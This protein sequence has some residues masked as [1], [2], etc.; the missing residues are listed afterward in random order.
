MKARIYEAHKNLHRQDKG[1]RRVV[2]M[3]IKILNL[4]AGIGGNRKL[5]IG[6]IEVTAVEI[7]P[8]IAKI[9]QDFFPQ[10]KVIIA[11]AHQFLLEHFKE[12]D[13]IWSSP[14]CQTHSD[15]NFFLNAQGV[16]RYPDM[17]LWQEIIFLKH[18]AKCLWVVENVQ[19]Y[20]K[21]FVKPYLCGRH[22]FWSNFIIANRKM[23]PSI[24]TFN[25]SA[26]IIKQ[27]RAET[28]QRKRN[29]VEPELGLHIFNMAFKHKQ[30]TL[31]DL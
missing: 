25:R 9:Y 31:V 17:A 12:F 20:Y 15:C 13:F 10:D 3:T 26:S 27:K 1:N 28:T 29:C 24:G 16:I 11:D 5:W 30:K 2:N 7:E 8:K 18:F 22:Y 4:Y 6:D 14:P 23:K 21:P 19:T